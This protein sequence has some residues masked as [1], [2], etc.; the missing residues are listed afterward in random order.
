MLEQFKNYFLKLGGLSSAEL[1]RSAEK[2]VVAENGNI[3]KLIAHIAEM[4]SRKVALKLGYKNLFE[5]CV[6]RLNLSEGAVPARIH[7]ANVSRRFPQLLVAL[8][9]TRISL[10]VASLL[11]A[12][13]TEDNVDKLITGA[14]TW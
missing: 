1:D 12:H 8:A 13:V 9:E 4:S 6:H 7:V 5:Y 11:A 14:A 3:A 10:T 2:L